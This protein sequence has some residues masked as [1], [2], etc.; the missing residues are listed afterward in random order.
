MDSPD[1]LKEYQK[2][3]DYWKLT[4]ELEEFAKVAREHNLNTNI[5]GFDEFIAQPVGESDVVCFHASEDR[6]KSIQ[7]CKMLLEKSPQKT[8]GILTRYQ[9]HQVQYL[10][11]QGLK[12]CIIEP[13]YSND[14]PKLLK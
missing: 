7:K 11:E 12:K 1:G 10:L 13:V 4:L 5:T 6:G 8:T 3:P 9:G 14:I 2:D